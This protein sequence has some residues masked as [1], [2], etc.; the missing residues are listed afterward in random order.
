LTLGGQIKVITIV[1]GWNYAWLL[2]TIRRCVAYHIPSQGHYGF[3][4]SNRWW[5]WR[6]QLN[7]S[8]VYLFL[9]VCFNQ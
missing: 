9:N 6:I 5:S 4:K 1:D 2:T 7:T 3:H 8:N